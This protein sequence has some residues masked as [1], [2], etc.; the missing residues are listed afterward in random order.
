MVAMLPKVYRVRHM[1]NKSCTRMLTVLLDAM[2]LTKMATHARF[3]LLFL[4]AFAVCVVFVFAGHSL[5]RAATV[6]PTEADCLAADRTAM[7]TMMTN[8]T[9]RPT[10]NVDIDFVAIMV[11]HHQGAIGMAQA[12][13]LYGHNQQLIWIAQGVI[14]QEMQEIAAMHSAIEQSYEADWIVQPQSSVREKIRALKHEAAYLSL[15]GSAVNRMMK[16]MNVHALG[17]VDRD[18]SAMMIPHHQG[19][20]SMAQAELRYGHNAELARL[21]QEIIVDQQQDIVLMRLAVGEAL[22]APKAAQ[23]QTDAMYKQN[24]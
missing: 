11:P 20:I 15:I 19:G 12:E 4:G 6:S 22:P 5:A 24:N 16:D 8:M 7:D 2:L 18:F 9:V 17:D 10:G 21:A 1:S 23:D 14:I 13:L 3:R